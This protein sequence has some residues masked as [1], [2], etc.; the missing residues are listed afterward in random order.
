MKSSFVV[1]WPNPRNILPFSRCKKYQPFPNLRHTI[2]GRVVE[3]KGRAISSL[4]E[5]LQDM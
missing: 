1:C 3:S 2:V 5:K 4:F